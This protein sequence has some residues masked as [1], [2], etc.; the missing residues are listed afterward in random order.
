MNE[1][2]PPSPGDRTGLRCIWLGCVCAALV[3]L[4]TSRAALAEP[5]EAQIRIEYVAPAGCPTE[6]DL[7]ARVRGRAPRVRRADKSDRVRTFVISIAS[8]D[9]ES[10]GHLVIRDA[11]GNEADRDIAGNTCEE[12]VDALALITALAV[13]PSALTNPRVP[14]PLPSPRVEEA[15]T[16]RSGRWHAA[17]TGAAGLASGVVPSPLVDLALLLEVDAPK[18]GF[19]S[20]ALRAGFEGVD[21]KS[22]AAHFGWRTGVVEVCP[23]QWRY[24]TLNLQPCVRVEAGILEGTGVNVVPARDAIR[25]WLAVGAV[26]RAQWF[27][28]IRTFVDLEAGLRFPLIRTRYFVEPDTTIYE[29]PNLG[30]VLSGGLGLRFL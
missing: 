22:D 15:P 24:A 1:R 20:P 9:G 6:E 12:V 16:P 11:D 8:V 28:S 7:F 2:A 23:T 13:D 3:G 17:L 14:A 26:A 19:L 29:P 5:N 4:A 30:V 25:A 21:Y 27:F 18:L 10:S